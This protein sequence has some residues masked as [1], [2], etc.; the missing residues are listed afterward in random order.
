MARGR[1]PKP[2]ELREAEENPGHRPLPDKIDAGKKLDL[3]PPA[4]LG[5][6]GRELWL[7]MVEQLGG[8]GALY[9]IDRVGLLAMCLQW[10]RAMAATGVLDEQ[11]HYAKGSM[12]QVVAHP[13]L[14]VERSAHTALLKFA[15]EYAA[16]PVAR[17]RVATARAAQ[18]QT[19]EFEEIVGELVDDDAE[20]DAEVL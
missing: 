10:D 14:G 17:A 1:K 3:E 15:A 18:R 8:I 9:S 4:I 7:E 12:G 11:G 20:I 5:P 19:E 6:A 13:A 2:V 16:T